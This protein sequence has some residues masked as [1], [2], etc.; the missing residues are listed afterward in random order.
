MS[1]A[2]EFNKYKKEVSKWIMESKMCVKGGKNNWKNSRV[3]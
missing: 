3:S 2:R 1:M